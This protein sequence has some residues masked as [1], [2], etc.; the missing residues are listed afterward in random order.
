MQQMGPTYI[1]STKYNL[2]LKFVK[3]LGGFTCGEMRESSDPQL[4]GDAGTA[5][6]TWAFTDSGHHPSIPQDGGKNPQQLVRGFIGRSQLCQPYVHSHWLEVSPIVF[7]GHAQGTGEY[8]PAQCPGKR[9]DVDLNGQ[10]AISA[11]LM[12]L[13][14]IQ[15]VLGATYLLDIVLGAW[16]IISLAH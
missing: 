11:T 5:V 14:F 2:F 8:S 3:T 16:F 1:G 13:F 4:F 15:H 7:F 12:H 9:E 6:S 10:V